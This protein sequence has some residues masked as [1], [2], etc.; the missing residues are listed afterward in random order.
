MR[1]GKVGLGGQA[2]RGRCRRDALTSSVDDND[3]A[4]IVRTHCALQHH[5]VALRVSCTVAMAIVNAVSHAT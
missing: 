2:R 1:F 4:M 5:G 3:L